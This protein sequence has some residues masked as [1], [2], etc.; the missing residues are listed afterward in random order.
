[1]FSVVLDEFAPFGY[2]NFAQILQTARGTNTAFLFSMQ[3]LP[4]LMQ[5][6]RGFKEDVTSAPNTTMTLRTRDEETA[7]YFLRASAEH[8]VTRRS[9]SVQRWKVFG[10]E[11]YE[12][13]GRAVESEDRETRA[14]DEHIK[15]L[16]KGQMEILMT[17]DTRGTLHTLLHVRRPAD[18]MIPNFEPELYPR[19]RHSRTDSV[20]AN[21]R[22]KSSEPE[23][24]TRLTRRFAGGMRA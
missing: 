16:P 1:M 10:Y 15:N 9:R 24:R 4:Q 17:D 19:L 23:A 8:Q 14:L 13:T 11:K 5:V 12:E 18:V 21:L 3:S 7:R 22:F 20:G 2:R 6:G